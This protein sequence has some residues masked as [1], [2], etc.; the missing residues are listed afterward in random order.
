MGGP[1]GRGGHSPD[2][3]SGLIPQEA[4]PGLLAERD[5][6]AAGMATRVGAAGREVVGRIGTYEIVIND[7]VRLLA[8]HGFVPPG[9]AGR[10]ATARPG[11]RVRGR[12]GPERGWAPR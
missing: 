3:G 6:I 9:R 7:A 10:R 2:S 8:D 12:C 11:R 5:R 1:G 4:I